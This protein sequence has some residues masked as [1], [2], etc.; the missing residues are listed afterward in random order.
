[1][2]K[3]LLLLLTFFNAFS[4]AQDEIQM[5][6]SE[7]N[8]LKSKIE[9]LTQQIDKE[10]T[11]NYSGTYEIEVWT[12]TVVVNYNKDSS[13]QKITM[14]ENLDPLASVKTIYIQK[15]Q[16]VY[17]KSLSKEWCEEVKGKQ[18]CDIK[19]SKCYFNENKFGFE[20]SRKIKGN[21]IKDPVTLKKLEISPVTEFIF[22]HLHGYDNEWRQLNYALGRQN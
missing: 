14:I 16:I 21:S 1:M 12:C 9:S 18:S 22:Q 20:A 11:L 10:A 3:T 17:I 15:N 8:D 19:E 5:T 4:F 13:F 7:K 6:A 2:K